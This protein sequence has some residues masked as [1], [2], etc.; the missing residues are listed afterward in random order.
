MHQRRKTQDEIDERVRTGE[1]AEVDMNIS[2]STHH[3]A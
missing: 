1:N 2:W 3:A